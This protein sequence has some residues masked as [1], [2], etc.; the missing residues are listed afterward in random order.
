MNI[1]RRTIKGVAITLVAGLVLTLS[2]CSGQTD[3]E[4]ALAKEQETS[5]VDGPSLEKTNLDRKK[6]LEENPNAIGY[7]YLLSKTGAFIGYYVTKGKISSNGSQAGPEDRIVWT[8]RNN[9][10]CQPV[11]LDSPQDD[12]SYGDGDPGI[13]FF[14]AAGVKI[15]TSMEY[16]HST[17]PLSINVPQL[18]K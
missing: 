14:T 16:V 11:V 7:V 18:T 4:K 17:Q 8:C 10:G 1:S 6:K 13:F 5:T 3:E 9:H 12:G 2:G 15:V